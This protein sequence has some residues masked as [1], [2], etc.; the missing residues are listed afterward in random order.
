[1]LGYATIGVNDMARAEAFYDG[2]I[3]ELGGRQLFGQDR[4]KFYGTGPDGAMLAI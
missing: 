2:L 3:A 4:I 1:M